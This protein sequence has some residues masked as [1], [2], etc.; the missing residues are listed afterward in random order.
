M[1]AE[2]KLTLQNTR[3]L[4]DIHGHLI[5]TVWIPSSNTLARASVAVLEVYDEK[6][7]N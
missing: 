4:R 2:I 3:L 7:F 1:T 6:D 5:T